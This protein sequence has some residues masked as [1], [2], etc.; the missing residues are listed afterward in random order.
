V[1]LHQRPTLAEVLGWPDEK[2]Y[3]EFIHGVV[4]E[5]A[6]PDFP[7]SVV[8]AEL[9]KVLGVW[10]DDFGGMVLTEQ[11]FVLD[12][13]GEE[14]ILLPDVCWLSA[15]VTAPARG[16]LRRP[17]TLAAEVLSPGD[18]YGKVQDKVMLYLHAGVRIVWIIDPEARNVSIY[19]PGMEPR[20]VP[21]SGVMDD[22]TLPGFTLAVQRLFRQVPPEND[23]QPP[24]RE[25]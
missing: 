2:P 4:L 11:R 10:A 20:V 19:R 23:T 15:E 14:H 21:L 16:P 1:T 18:R 8:Q 13:Q 7:H 5:K 6:W 9:A 3:V 12:A 25:A 22:P 24:V 17:P